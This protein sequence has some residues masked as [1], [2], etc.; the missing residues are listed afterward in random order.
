MLSIKLKRKTMLSIKLKRI[1]AIML[2]VA[3]LST[4]LT[5]LEMRN[6]LVIGQEDLDQGKWVVVLTTSRTRKDVVSSAKHAYI[7]IETS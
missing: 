2:T 6:V 1:Y 3:F 5:L 7:Y 4:F